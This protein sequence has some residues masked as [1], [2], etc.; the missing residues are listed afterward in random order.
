LFSYGPVMLHEALV[1]SEILD[2]LGVSVAVVNHPWLNAFDVEWLTTLIRPYA[3]V[4]V[5]EDHGVTGALGDHLLSVLVK[6]RL[7]G[8]R[9]FEVFGVDGLPACG[10]PAE[11]L[12][13]HHL[14][15]AS[16]ARRVMASLELRST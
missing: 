4:F 10:T 5:L 6:H 15:G 12:A 7:L 9:Y 11:A 16:L 1:A 8:D 2:T 13:V 14:D 3:S